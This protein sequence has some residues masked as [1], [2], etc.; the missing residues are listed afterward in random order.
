MSTAGSSVLTRKHNS[1]L[2]T[3]VFPTPNFRNEFMP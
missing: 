1:S 3:I 2:P